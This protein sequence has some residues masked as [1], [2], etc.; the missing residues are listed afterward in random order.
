MRNS[1][2]RGKTLNKYAPKV[3]A[4]VDSGRDFPTGKTSLRASY[5]QAAMV[6]SRQTQPNSL[7]GDIPTGWGCPQ[8]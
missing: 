3:K 8:D 1:Y 5:F 7:L 6:E 4:G 2:L